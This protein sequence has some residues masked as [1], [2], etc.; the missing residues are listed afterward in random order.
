MKKLL[1]LL[2]WVGVFCFTTFSFA[3]DLGWVSVR[4]C[5]N[6][7]ETK[8]LNLILESGVEWEICIDFLNESSD[9]KIWFCGWCSYS[10]S[11]QK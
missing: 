10:R 7:E 6:D 2:I 8:N 5:N 11:V 1:S 9:Y 3:Q 4:F